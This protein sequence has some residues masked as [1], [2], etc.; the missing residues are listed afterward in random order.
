MR[1]WY[2]ASAGGSR[3]DLSVEGKAETVLTCRMQSGFLGKG[4][5]LLAFPNAGCDIATYLSGK[6]ATDEQLAQTMSCPHRTGTQVSYRS[7]AQ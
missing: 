3:C 7:Q 5:T 1:R 2:V 6:T 4:E